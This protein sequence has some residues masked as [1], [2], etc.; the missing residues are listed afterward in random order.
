M[1]TLRCPTANVW[2]KVWVVSARIE[3]LV[4]H[5]RVRVILRQER[6]PAIVEEDELLELQVEMAAERKRALSAAAATRCE[7]ARDPRCRCRCGGAAHGL[8]RGPTWELPPEDPHHSRM[9][10]ELQAP[11][12]PFPG[13]QADPRLSDL[14]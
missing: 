10:E 2:L 4:H 14:A 7:E 13:A 3:V 12:L 11:E 1:K 8:R 6:G 5:G 9:P